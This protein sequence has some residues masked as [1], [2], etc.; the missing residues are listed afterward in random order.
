MLGKSY[1]VFEFCDCSKAV[2]PK[3]WYSYDSDTRESFTRYASYF[4][5][6]INL[7]RHSTFKTF[8]LLTSNNLGE[9][10]F[11]FCWRPCFSFPLVTAI[12]S[13]VKRQIFRRISFFFISAIK[14]AVKCLSFRRIPI[15]DPIKWW[16]PSGTLLGLDV[17]HGIKRLLTP[18]VQKHC[19]EAQSGT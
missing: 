11:I 13:V 8:I 4:S 1:V 7:R 10:Y 16:W 17:A 5:L 2:V 12:E 14:L 3:L 18:V 19:T 15:F 6:L 9:A